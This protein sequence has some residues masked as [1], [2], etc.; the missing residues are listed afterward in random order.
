MDAGTADTLNRQT[1]QATVKQMD[2][3]D[4]TFNNEV[5]WHRAPLADTLMGDSSDRAWL[6]VA[7]ITGAYDATFT[8]PADEDWDNLFSHFR[9]EIEARRNVHGTACPAAYTYGATCAHTVDCPNP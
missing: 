7:L 5:G 9:A 8:G 6:A 2:I 4:L 1:V 3:L